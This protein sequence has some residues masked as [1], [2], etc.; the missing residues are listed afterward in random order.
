MKN[1][2]SLLFFLTITFCYSQ[3]NAKKI[4]KEVYVERT[5]LTDNDK[6]TEF[7]EF[8]ITGEPIAEGEWS[9]DTAKK[10]YQKKDVYKIET[11]KEKEY[12]YEYD[13]NKN[14]ISKTRYVKEGKYMSFVGYVKSYEVLLYNY[15]NKLHKSIIYCAKIDTLDAGR[16]Q[17]NQDPEGYMS[18][19]KNIG[20]E[21][22]KY[23]LKK[24][25]I[26]QFNEKGQTVSL[27]SLF[28][29]E[30]AE[31]DSYDDFGNVNSY[32]KYKLRHNERNSNMDF[33]SWYSGADL[34]SEMFSAENR[35]G[36]YT[37]NYKYDAFGNWIEKLTFI[38]KK[39]FEKKVRHIVYF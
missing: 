37:V 36:E 9:F 21:Y 13:K 22:L 31:Y 30:G 7:I 26:E 2:I 3:N 38:D 11:E 4:I 16:E 1:I 20:V 35:E 18:G 32:T 29:L 27:V 10:T 39:E 19:A 5:D 15:K 28:S 14:I 17:F 34:E 6:H 23:D 8:N 33:I 25:Y 12:K 24:T